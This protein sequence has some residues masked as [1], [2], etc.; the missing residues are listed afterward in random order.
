MRHIARMLAC[1]AILFGGSA[2]AQI[3]R[4]DAC[5]L[6]TLA[7]PLSERSSQT[8]APPAACGALPV[9]EDAWTMDANC[10]GP[11][12][13]LLES[14]SYQF[15]TN[16]PPG[17]NVA[18]VTKVKLPVGDPNAPPW[19]LVEDVVILPCRA[20]SA[21][22]P[23]GED[24]APSSPPP[25]ILIDDATFPPLSTGPGAAPATEFVLAVILPVTDLANPFGAFNNLDWFAVVDFDSDGSHFSQSPSPDL[26]GNGCPDSCIELGVPGRFLPHVGIDEVGAGLVDFLRNHG[27][28]GLTRI[29]V[30]EPLPTSPNPAT[31]LG[32]QMG[33]TG[34][35]RPW[36]FRFVLAP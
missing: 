10:L 24:F 22:N 34:N 19:R 7:F 32:M 21:Q 20:R 27:T 13:D 4:I 17:V 28:L 29:D 26:D 15:V 12:S 16:L 23:T 11:S 8:G 2:S 35:T 18:F 36:C 5:T 33:E 31:L 14:E 30:F 1:A 3:R 6:Q 9:V 25:M